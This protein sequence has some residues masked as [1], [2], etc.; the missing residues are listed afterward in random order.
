MKTSSAKQ[1]GRKLQQ[2]VRDQ[3]LKD[4]PTWIKEDDVRSTGMGQQ[5][6]DVQLSTAG[7]EYFPFA[8]ECK[9]RAKQAI[10]KDYEQAQAHGKGTLLE[11][12]VILKQNNSKPLAVV[13]AEFF[14]DT[15]IQ[16]IK[17]YKR[18]DSSDTRQS[19]KTGS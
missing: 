2:F 5:G 16:F 11:P 13:D 1:K 15:M 9:S 4:A 7:R 14:I 10:Y 12:L 8:V 3:I 18:E 19:S 6:A 17:G